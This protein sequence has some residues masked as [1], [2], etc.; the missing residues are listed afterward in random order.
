M[1]LRPCPEAG[2]CSPARRADSYK[3]KTP[4]DATCVPPPGGCRSPSRCP[5]GRPRPPSAQTG[6]NPSGPASRASPDR[7]CCPPG[8]TGTPCT[9]AHA[10]G[11]SSNNCPAPDRSGR[12]HR[13]HSHRPR[14]SDGRRT[15]RRSDTA[16]RRPNSWQSTRPGS[17]G[18]C[19]HSPTA[20][21][22][23]CSPAHRN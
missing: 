4:R 10:P 14:G 11:R 21:F 6:A 19:P 8:R 20:G 17:S 7:R 12:S 15:L 18:D 23:A 1:R 16:P 3:D 2:S 13:P 9:R 22:P 5:S